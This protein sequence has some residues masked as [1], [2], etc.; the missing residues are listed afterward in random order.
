MLSALPEPTIQPSFIERY[1]LPWRALRVETGKEFHVGR[2]L[3]YRGVEPFL[4]TYR[5]LRR[6]PAEQN[7][8]PEYVVKPLFQSYIFAAWAV[9]DLRAVLQAPGVIDV[10]KC[11]GR[12]V[13]LEPAEMERLRALGTMVGVEPWQRIVEGARIMVTEGPLR[14]AIGRLLKR[15]STVEVLIEVEV[16]GRAC[17]VSLEGWQ[18][19]EL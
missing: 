18:I 4:P 7:K 16:L 2:H 17:K 15:N 12:M 14:G 3:S 5:T 8:K 6:F 9:S 19:E 11:D 10:L 1:S 13:E